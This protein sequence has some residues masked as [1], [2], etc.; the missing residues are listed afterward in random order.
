MSKFSQTNALLNL[1]GRHILVVGGTQG[2]GAA[3]AK[4]C[5]S[6]G[7]SVTILGRN[8]T[9]GASVVASLEQTARDKEKQ[10]FAMQVVDVTSIK[11]VKEFC[12]E[13]RAKSGS[14]S[15]DGLVLCA[16]GLNW[17]P[18]RETA[19]GIES[20]FALNYLSRF[21]LVRELLPLLQASNHGARVV[22]V[23][24]PGQGGAINTTDWQLKQPSAFSFVKVHNQILS[25]TDVI[26]G[27]FARRY[28]HASEA[29]KASH[30][31]S[32]FHMFPGLVNT[33]EL[34]NQGLPSYI[35]GPV[36]FLAPLIATPP[37][38]TAQTIV[39]LLASEEFGRPE[40]NGGLVGPRTQVLR[41]VKAVV[42]GGDALV[43]QVWNYSNELANSL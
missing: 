37:E 12:K 14:N 42:E 11:S 19:E 43:Q 7:A 25:M 27:E 20:T 34:R 9:L 10:S 21:V 8:T 36:E 41:P 5:A 38:T 39:H 15:L 6:L 24:S 29:A 1:S 2:I 31:V 32:F 22:N 18:R 33:K 35:Y 23:L 40:R 3:T 17:G 13:L 30:P 16:G 4:A 26:T 28:G